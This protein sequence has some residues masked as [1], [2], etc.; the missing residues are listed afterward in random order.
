MMQVLVVFS[1]QQRS[2][3]SMCDRLHQEW[4]DWVC[5]AKQRNTE[6][7]ADVACVK[8]RELLERTPFPSFDGSPES[9]AEFKR[10]FR[11]LISV[12]GHGKALEL[13]IGSKSIRKPQRNC[14]HYHKSLPLSGSD[15]CHTEANM[16]V[17]SCSR[18]GAA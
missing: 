10:V 1:Q 15:Y 8:Q 3:T 4:F 2:G 9:W 5:T 11:E 16:V 12:S 18:R 6:N 7:G 13:G 14:P 17:R